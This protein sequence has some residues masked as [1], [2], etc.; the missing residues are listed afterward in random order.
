MICVIFLQKQPIKWFRR[1][2]QNATSGCSDVDVTATFSFLFFLMQITSVKAEIF[3][4][5]AVNLR[6]QSWTGF[7]FDMSKNSGIWFKETFPVSYV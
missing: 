4:I 2:I 6:N 5:N 3:N 7:Y 1:F